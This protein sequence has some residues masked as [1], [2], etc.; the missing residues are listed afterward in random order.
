VPTAGEL[1]LV[2]LNI[3]T[4]ITGVILA[5]KDAF[6]P[7]VQLFLAERDILSAATEA[8]PN[9]RELTDRRRQI[10][11][12]PGGADRS[13]FFGND[14]SKLSGRQERVLRQLMFKDVDIEYRPAMAPVGV[15]VDM[16]GPDRQSVFVWDSNTV[17]EGLDSY[18]HLADLRTLGMVMSNCQVL[19]ALHRCHEIREDTIAESDREPPRG[20]MPIEAYREHV[21]E[22]LR[23]IGQLQSEVSL[24]VEAHVLAT[25]VAGGR[26]L[27]RY[28][29]SVVAE[30]SLPHLLSMTQHLLAAV[31]DAVRVEQELLAVQEARQ[32]AQKQISIAKATKG[33]LD[34]SEDFKA[35]TLIFAAVAVVIGLAG[36]F[37]S[38]A[39]MPKTQ[40]DTLLRST[41]G[42]LLFVIS[43]VVCAAA[44][45]VGLRWAS[46]VTLDRRWRRWTR[47]VRGA[48][49]VVLV[50][51]VL[52]ALLLAVSAPGKST[53]PVLVG[54]LIAVAAAVVLV[55]C[56]A[57]ELNFETP[58]EEI[59]D[60]QGGSQSTADVVA[61]EIWPLAV[62][63]G[64]VHLWRGSPVGEPLTDKDRRR[65]ELLVEERVHVLT[66]GRVR[67]VHSTSWRSAGSTIVLTYVALLDLNDKSPDWIPVQPQAVR[68]EGGSAPGPIH[69]ADVLNHALGHLAFLVTYR[70]QESQEF[71]SA[72]QEALQQ[73]TPQLAGELLAIPDQ[74]R[75][76]AQRPAPG[77]CR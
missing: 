20:A 12:L 16:N 8:A 28:H 62:I 55:F 26:P 72:W 17:A 65:I 41:P 11:F 23:R 57:L 21:E 69:T 44:L 30:S 52:S 73:W 29:E 35:A 54:V 6:D 67:Y 47:I 48:S 3:C 61:I 60:E 18:P 36:L 13:G 76:G 32:A 25:G 56:L 38:A 70:R 49:L 40:S 5:E 66:T 75:A 14:P 31:G 51:A 9:S 2:D 42:S 34:Q 19:G 45:G 63:D 77:G 53:L 15:P 58:D 27:R 59:P 37:A 22:R 71:D 64:Q 50:G 74:R 33:L 10:L 4:T 43:A 7:N 39:A 1:L 46:R 68:P 24:G